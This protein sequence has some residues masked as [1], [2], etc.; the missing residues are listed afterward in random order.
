MTIETSRA[1]WSGDLHRLST[2]AWCEDSA[3]AALVVVHQGDATG[4]INLRHVH[5]D[6]TRLVWLWMRYA[7]R[8]RGPGDVLYAD[9]LTTLTVLYRDE[10]QEA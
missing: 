4:W 10:P 6:Q 9:D 3:V 8:H 2:R 7:A 5:A 1:V